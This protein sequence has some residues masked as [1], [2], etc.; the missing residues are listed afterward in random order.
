MYRTLLGRRL[1]KYIY[2]I[3]T[4]GGLGDLTFLLGMEVAYYTYPTRCWEAIFSS[5][6]FSLCL[7]ADSSSI[8]EKNYSIH[9][10]AANWYTL[11]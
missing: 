3:Y 7:C 9:N 8:V 5:F 1:G 10:T 11:Q 6:F 2:A 4:F